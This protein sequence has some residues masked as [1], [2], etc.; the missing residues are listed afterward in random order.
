MAAPLVWSLIVQ[1]SHLI[2]RAQFLLHLW[3]FCLIFLTY[4]NK[5]QHLIASLRWIVLQLL[6]LIAYMS[7]LC[8]YFGLFFLGLSS[9]NPEEDKQKEPIWLL[10]TAQSLRLQKCLHPH[11][12]D[13]DDEVLCCRLTNTFA[14]HKEPIILQQEQVFLFFSFVFSLVCNSGSCNWGSRSSSSIIC[15]CDPGAGWSSL[16][17]YLSLIMGS[18]CWNILPFFYHFK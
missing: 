4:C 9:W 2:P 13:E 7:F 6:L 14:V 12:H 5:K 8:F 16:L 3:R 1:L 11:H 18:F 17:L 15:M 10:A